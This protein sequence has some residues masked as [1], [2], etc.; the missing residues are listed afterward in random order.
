MAD[1]A[2]VVDPFWQCID[3]IEKL[4]KCLPG[5]VDTFQHGIPGQVFRT[6]KIPE[7]EVC[8]FLFTR[9]QG[10]P[11]VPHHDA[12]HTVIAR[13]GTE[14]IP[15]HLCIH[16]RMP[17]DESRADHMAFRIDVL[18]SRFSDSADVR[19]FTVVYTDICPVACATGAIDD[20]AVPDN[21]VVSHGESAV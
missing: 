7:D 8:I 11:A 21:Q 2:C 16:M 12:G 20:S 6:L 5:P 10:E 1:I 3:R 13:A 19:D 15:E 17:I 18:A 14:W 4:R 9:G